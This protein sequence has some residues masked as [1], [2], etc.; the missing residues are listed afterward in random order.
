MAADIAQMVNEVNLWLQQGR[1]QDVVRRFLRD[2]V[3][4]SQER[5]VRG[6]PGIAKDINEKR[7]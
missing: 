5:V 1:P 3:T 4:P 7:A 2:R 6:K